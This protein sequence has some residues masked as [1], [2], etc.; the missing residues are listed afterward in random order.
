VHDNFA[1]LNLVLLLSIFCR[2]EGQSEDKTINAKVIGSWKQ[3][4]PREHRTISSIYGDTQQPRGSASTDKT[5]EYPG[6]CGDSIGATLGFRYP[7]TRLPGPSAA[8]D[9]WVIDWL[10]AQY[11]CVSRTT[12]TTRASK[13]IKAVNLMALH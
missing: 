1:S 12:T 5:P 13:P 6:D 3:Q 11:H 7:F 9:S 4:R 2:Q 10:P 8:A